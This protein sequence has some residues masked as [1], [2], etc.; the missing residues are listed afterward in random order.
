[1]TTS[2]TTDA[3]DRL[4]SLLRRLSPPTPPSLPPGSRT[5][6]ALE[7]AAHGW[8]GTHRSAES[9]LLDHVHEVR[10]FLAR[11]RDLDRSLF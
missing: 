11:V 1:M 3:T 2:A 4:T 7:R 9:A 5:S 8:T 10:D 6:A